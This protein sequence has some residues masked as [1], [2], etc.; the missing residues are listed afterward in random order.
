MREWI[1]ASVLAYVV[2][3]CLGDPAWLPHP[4]IAIGRLITWLERRLYPGQR[5]H[6]APRLRARIAGVLLLI[7]TAGLTM[8]VAAL[9]LALAARGGA[10]LHLAVSVALLW[11]ALAIRSLI[12]HGAAVA[13]ALDAGDQ[14]RARQ[15]AG[16]MVSRETA[17]LTPSE[18]ARACIESLAENL[19]DGVLSPFLFGCAGGPVAAWG[20]KA[21]ST[22]DSM[23]GYRNPR[24]QDFGWAAAR[25]DDV[26]HYFPARTLWGVLPL[27]SG[28]LGHS[29]SGC[30][31]AMRR[32]GGKSPSPNSGLP[33][34]G[35]AGALGNELGGPSIYGGVWEN[36]ARLNEGAPAPQPA[37][38]R[39]ALRL[40]L[41]ASAVPV[42][43]LALAAGVRG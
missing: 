25:C 2:D 31:R 5:H 23:V 3:L 11:M 42:M 41:A 26:L 8:A 6:P 24:Y 17:A 16:R 9:L 27:A 30:W 37:D 10:A 33:E 13:G 28:G 32:D 7:L 43:V 36:K 21:V 19:T 39:R 35:V 29:V 22:L 34:A 15:L 12:E 4:V 40:V 38:I 20:L 14:P 18:V 1:L